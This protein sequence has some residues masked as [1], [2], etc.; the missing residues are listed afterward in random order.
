MKRIL[1]IIFI[2]V[3]IVL[4][5]IPNLNDYLIKR[6]I[7]KNIELVEEISYDEI[8]ENQ[9]RD[10]VFDY[11]SIRDVSISTVLSNSS[12][13]NNKSII[14]FISIDD[15]N[16]NLP[17]LKGVTDTNLLVGATTMRQSQEM[18]K[19]NYPL[20]GHYLR[21]KTTLF[22]PLLDIKIGTIVKITN[23]RVVYEYEVY[24]TKIVPETAMYMLEDKE[25]EDRGKPIISLMTCYFT[26]S[27]GK[28]FF[29]LGE[30]IDS[31]PYEQIIIES[32]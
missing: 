29:V 22:G 1:S 24:D 17:I 19:G 28:R 25:A 23:K 3:G 12:Y 7:E 27:N 16:I 26:S 21:G 30:L 11:S 2:L 5:A 10:A 13:F 15:L 32:E 4:L 8:E 14:G 31:Y 20:A 6:N 9:A 18:G